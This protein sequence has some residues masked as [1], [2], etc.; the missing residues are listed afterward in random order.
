MNSKPLTLHDQPV[1][2]LGLE[3]YCQPFRQPLV[4]AHG[5]WRDRA[6][7]LVTLTDEWGRRGCG[8]I[9]PIATF[10]T[11]T[12]A[13]AGELCRAFGDRVTGAQIAQIPDSYPAC[14]FGL[15]TA[16]MNLQAPESVPIRLRPAQVAHLVS[17]NPGA[18]A[19]IEPWYSQGTRTLKCKIGVQAGAIERAAFQDLSERVPPDVQFRLDANGNLTPD[20]LE[21]WGNLGKQLGNIE[22]LEQPFPPEQLAQLCQLQSTFPIPLALDE[23]V[24]TWPALQT[25]YAQGWRGIY[26]IKVAIAGWP[27]RWLNF[28]QTH[29]LDVVYSSVF[30][31]EIGRQAA[32]RIIQHYPSARALGFGTQNW[33]MA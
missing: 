32:L 10:G 8:E 15:A 6:G 19:T 18:I 5:I 29:Q 26:V 13:A 3:P 9:A 12:V 31:T 7:W 23:S 17:L 30:E 1:W 16:L 4:T 2:Q 20:E 27:E 22:F 25:T 11:E 33:F 21:Q 14:Q 24:A 28:C